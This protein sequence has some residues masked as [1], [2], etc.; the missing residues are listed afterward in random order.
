MTSLLSVACCLQLSTLLYFAVAEPIESELRDNAVK[1]KSL[2]KKFFGDIGKNVKIPLKS[3]NDKEMI[4]GSKGAPISIT[5]YFSLS[6]PLTKKIYQENAS[7]FGDYIKN[8][9]IKILLK[10]YVNGIKDFEICMLFLGMVKNFA[11]ELKHLI[12]LILVN[13]KEIFLEKNEEEGIKF[14]HDII[15]SRYEITTEGI[16]GYLTDQAIYNKL[17]SAQRQ[18]KQIIK[19]YSGPVFIIK[20]P[21]SEEIYE[22]ITSAEE[23][24]EKCG[25]S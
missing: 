3:G 24:L 10:L 9:K 21:D 25:L 6:C 15:L 20:T 7:K 13:Q 1:R 8:K 23:L 18:A 4:I 14:I 17:V 12:G 5:C 16:S 2:K 11:D 19:K 22:E